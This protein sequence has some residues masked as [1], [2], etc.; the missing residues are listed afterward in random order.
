MRDKLLNH[1]PVYFFFV[2]V[3]FFKFYWFSII[4]KIYVFIILINDNDSNNVLIYERDIV[5]DECSIQNSV[6]F[7]DYESRITDENTIYT[8]L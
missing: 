8:T 1:L 5:F 4:W 7:I 3:F 6:K 2:S